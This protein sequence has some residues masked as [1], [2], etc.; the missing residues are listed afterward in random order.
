MYMLFYAKTL[1]QQHHQIGGQVLLLAQEYHLLG[2]CH[3]PL[4]MTNSP[5]KMIN[6]H[7]ASTLPVPQW[8]WPNLIHPKTRLPNQIFPS[9]RASWN[10]LP[11]PLNARP[12]FRYSVIKIEGSNSPQRSHRLCYIREGREKDGKQSEKEA[13]TKW[14]KHLKKK[15]NRISIVSPSTQGLDK[16]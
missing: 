9:H 10:S 8:N 7:G 12:S 15:R 14:S 6:R 2:S 16:G 1:M 3:T 5:R 4:N 11:L 13:A